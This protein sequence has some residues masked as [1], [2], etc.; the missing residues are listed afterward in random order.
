M[1]TV[2]PRKVLALGA[3]LIVILAAG[4]AGGQGLSNDRH[5]YGGGGG[6]FGSSYPNLDGSA[7][8][9]PHNNVY[10]RLSPYKSNYGERNNG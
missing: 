9:Y 4:C 7:G 2:D 10:G 1:R 3:L 6:G 5:G 8:S